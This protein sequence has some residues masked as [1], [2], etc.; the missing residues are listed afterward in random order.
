MKRFRTPEL[1]I[2]LLFLGICAATALVTA[3]FLWPTPPE[4]PGEFSNELTELSSGSPPSPGETI[5][6]QAILTATAAQT[7]NTP[8]APAPLP[9]LIDKPEASA[10]PASTTAPPATPIEG[11]GGDPPVGKI[12][13]TCYI[14]AIDQI[15]L[16]NADGTGRVQLTEAG[17]TSFYPSIAAD[18]KSIVFSSRR[19]GNFELFWLLLENGFTT[20]VTSGIGSLFAPEISPA[21]DRV[22]FANASGGSQSIW[23]M[24]LDGSDAFPLT[25]GPWDDVDPTW[26]P[27]GS[28]IAFASSRS[29]ARQLFV[30]D[31]DGSDV[32]QVTN[33]PDMG[34]RSSWSP[35][36]ERLVFYAGPFEDRDIFTIRVDGSDLFQVT[37][38]GDNL[39]PSW[40]QDG[41]WIA[42]TS[43]RDGN[44]EIYIVRPDGANPVNLTRSPL[45]EWQPRWGVE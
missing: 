5:P 1:V 30:M 4:G 37:N 43:F 26:S 17:A 12:A 13:F 44:N 36:G 14:A 27:D 45:S 32:V 35:D 38:G 18:G 24:A 19:T 23:V 2:G 16:M 39:G 28:R 34:G 9:T 31:A 29:G 33:L 21:G 11:W 7:G 3:V 10:T 40:S 22:V 25:S 8:T 6:V 41:A 20:Q 42:F 15:C